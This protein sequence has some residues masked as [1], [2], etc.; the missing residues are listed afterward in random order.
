[1]VD[2]EDT[3]ADGGLLLDQDDLA[4]GLGGLE[5]GGDAGD[6]GADHE[7]GQGTGDRGQG[8]GTRTGP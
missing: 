6:A 4:A 5:G 3:P 1:M 2:A 7:Q 8:T